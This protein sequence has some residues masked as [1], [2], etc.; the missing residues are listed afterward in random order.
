[1]RV[2]KGA[3]CSSVWAVSPASGGSSSGASS[4]SARASPD[5]SATAAVMVTAR[6]RGELT[7]GGSI[8]RASPPFSPAKR[9]PPGGG[10]LSP[11]LR[12][13]FFRLEPQLL[14]PAPHRGP[15][16]PQGPRHLRHPPTVLLE[17]GLQLL[18][19]R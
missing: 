16:P 9:Q 7:A 15:L 18:R 10:R 14:D 3:S 4:R 19:A 11:R 8:G 12:P 13:K 6:R 5:S 2:L 1:M 17:Q